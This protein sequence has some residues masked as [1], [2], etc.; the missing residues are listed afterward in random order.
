MKNPR[1][2]SFVLEYDGEIT[3]NNGYIEVESEDI[4]AITF[5]LGTKNAEISATSSGDN[6]PPQIFISSNE[7]KVGKSTLI[8][9]PE[10]YEWEIFC[11]EIAR[12]T[13][14]ICLIKKAKDRGF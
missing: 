14:R 6:E 9:L 4:T 1:P 10:Y 5:D 2:V 8:S 11:G 12:Y 7:S 13:M 3:V